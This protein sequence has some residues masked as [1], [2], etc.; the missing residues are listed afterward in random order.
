MLRVA[1]IGPGKR[2][3]FTNTKQKDDEESPPLVL[4]LVKCLT[5]AVL[6]LS[7]AVSPVP[8]PADPIL[9]ALSDSPGLSAGLTG[10]ELMERS[11]LV[12]STFY[13]RLKVLVADG[14]VAKLGR[15]RTALYVPVRQGDQLP[16]DRL[17][18][19]QSGQSDAVAVSPSPGPT[20][21]SDGGA[22]LDG[23]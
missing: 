16:L 5:S 22:G 14:A 2:F 8:V 9:A 23:P 10:P 4:D 6:V 7:P 19:A 13:D 18:P 15:G 21:S 1:R 12:R 3:E 20:I 17:S 11:G